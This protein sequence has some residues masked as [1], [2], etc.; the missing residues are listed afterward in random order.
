MEKIKKQRFFV[1][2]QQIGQNVALN[3]HSM[4][5][6][7]TQEQGKRDNPYLIYSAANVKNRETHQKWLGD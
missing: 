6:K 5:Q 4:S 7:I 3:Q 1:I 2:R